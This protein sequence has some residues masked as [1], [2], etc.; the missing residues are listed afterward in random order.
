M[1]RMTG[2]A[3]EQVARIVGGASFQMMH[4]DVKSIPKRQSVAL[5]KD[6]REILL[7]PTT[8]KNSNT[9]TKHAH[10]LR[11]RFTAFS[12]TA[13]PSPSHTQ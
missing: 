11:S 1:L 10:A 8:E 7:L 12:H 13:F 2:A 9:K 5:C 3:E 6:V 4:P